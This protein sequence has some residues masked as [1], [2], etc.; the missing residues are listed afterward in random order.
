V[1]ERSNLGNR[2]KHRTFEIDVARAEEG[3]W[4]GT[5]AAIRRLNIEGETSEAAIVEARTSAPELLRAN[6]VVT[7]DEVIE[8]LSSREGERLAT[9]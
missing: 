6:G 3:H 1:H 5:S 7:D 8:L 4:T 2:A 9:E